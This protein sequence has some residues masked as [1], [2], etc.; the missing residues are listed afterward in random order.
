MVGPGL[1]FLTCLATDL[2]SR[3][4]AKQLQGRQPKVPPLRLPSSTASA[5]VYTD[6]RDLAAYLSLTLI[7][8]TVEVV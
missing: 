6:C 3:S 2:A 1:T 4:A 5:T 7:W 8:S